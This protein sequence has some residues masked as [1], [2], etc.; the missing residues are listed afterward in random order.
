MTI[1]VDITALQSEIANDPAALGYAG[2]TPDE[3]YA[4][5]RASTTQRDR[6]VPLK[7][8]QSLLMETVVSPA[9]VPVW[10]VL[11]GAAASDPLAEM[12]FDLFSSRL[13]N[14]NT[15]GA[16]QAAALGQLE[17]A[18]IL[19]AALR[20]Q[21]DAMAVETVNRGVL[22]YGRMPTSLEIAVAQQMV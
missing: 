21:I 9:T 8:L 12:A 7:D 11:K 22:L 3:I 18:G 14:L 17:T 1:E 15:R 19:D 4:L 10:W 20:A 13:E 6:F 16:F 2:K 5:M